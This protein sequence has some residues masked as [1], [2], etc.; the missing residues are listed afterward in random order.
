[1]VL[2][3]IVL[4]AISIVTKQ[5]VFAWIAIVIAALMLFS[6]GPSRHVGYFSPFSG[7]SIHVEPIWYHCE[8]HGNVPIHHVGRPTDCPECHKQMTKGKKV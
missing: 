5:A 4:V 6:G 8:E 1:M 3:L 7:G 2:I